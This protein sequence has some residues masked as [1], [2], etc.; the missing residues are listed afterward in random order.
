MSF[1][2]FYD[3][4]FSLGV[5]YVGSDFHSA[6]HGGLHMLVY[7]GAHENPAHFQTLTGLV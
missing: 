3:N 1:K 7:P 2:W 5:A 4:F 6:G